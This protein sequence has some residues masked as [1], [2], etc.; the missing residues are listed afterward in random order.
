MAVSSSTARKATE[1]SYLSGQKTSLPA[2]VLRRMT[3]VYIISSHLRRVC[4]ISM[5]DDTEPPRSSLSSRKEGAAS[6]H[7][8]SGSWNGSPRYLVNL[9]QYFSLNSPWQRPARQ[10]TK[11]FNVRASL[12]VGPRLSV[13][14]PE[15]VQGIPWRRR[16]RLPA[17][18]PRGRT[19]RNFATR[20]TTSSSVPSRPDAGPMA[21]WQEIPQM[22]PPSVPFGF[23]GSQPPP[24]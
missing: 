23:Q 3:G 6:P 19:C 13:V 4:I 15:G 2:F 21:P 7:W 11:D 20:R 14:F 16:A 10:C 1:I 9:P 5:I 8:A 17:S 12:F 24:G 22:L 18:D